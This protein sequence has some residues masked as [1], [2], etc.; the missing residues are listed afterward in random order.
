MQN[1][2]Y[3]P[4]LTLLCA[5]AYNKNRVVDTPM[6]PMFLHSP[7]SYFLSLK[8]RIVHSGYKIVQDGSSRIKIVKNPQK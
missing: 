5:M 3:T 2:L 8:H 4:Y 6:S 7:T 1:K